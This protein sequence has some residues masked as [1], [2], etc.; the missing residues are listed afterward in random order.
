MEVQVAKP[1]AI[2][3][4]ASKTSGIEEG[5]VVTFTVSSPEPVDFTATLHAYVSGRLAGEWKVHVVNGVGSIRLVPS[6]IGTVVDWQAE[7]FGLKSNVVTTRLRMYNTSIS[8]G[9]RRGSW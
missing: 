6:V 1:S 2:Y 3:L 9:A 4:Q 8:I 7:A 5:E